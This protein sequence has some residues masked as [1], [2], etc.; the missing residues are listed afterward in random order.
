MKICRVVE[1]WVE[2]YGKSP[3]WICDKLVG[4][5]DLW[6]E[7]WDAPLHR[8]CLNQFMKT[9]EYRTIVLHGHPIVLT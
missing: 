4:M 8:R 5:N 9:S 2:K 6:I 1:S 7:E 3:C